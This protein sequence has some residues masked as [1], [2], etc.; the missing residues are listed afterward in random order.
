MRISVILFF[1]C[2]IQDPKLSLKASDIDLIVFSYDRPMQLFAYLES[3]DKHIK[4]INKIFVLYRTSTNAFDNGYDEIKKAFPS[5][6]FFQQTR[7]FSGDFKPILLHLCFKA[8]KTNYIMF[9]VDDIMVTQSANLNDCL[10]TLEETN[11]YAFYLRLGKNIN[12]CYG[13]SKDQSISL[14][15][16]KE[17]KP[18]IFSWYF[19]GNDICNPWYYP[20]SIDMTIFKKKTIEPALKELAYTSPNTLENVWSNSVT[21]INGEKG[22]CFASSV[23]VNIPLNLVQDYQDKHMHFSSTKNLLTLFQ[24]GFKI[25]INKFINYENKATHEEIAPHFISRKFT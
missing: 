13:L 3:L 12:T 20:H 4:N 9:G 2:L 5:I 23:M 19:F 18:S 25:D 15:V 24:H 11:Y 16:L 14:P 22:L 7:N 6:D 8:S 10:Q 1:L 17:L 21:L